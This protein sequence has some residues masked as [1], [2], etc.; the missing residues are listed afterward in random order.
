MRQRPIGI[1]LLSTLALLAGIGAAFQA[2]TSLDP[3]SVGPVG[4]VQAGGGF[5]PAAIGYMIAAGI[6]VQ[7]SYGPWD[8]KRWAWFLAPALAIVHVAFNI[9]GALVGGPTWALAGVGSVIPLVILAYLVTAGVR[10]A[11]RI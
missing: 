11:F 7:L 5:G 1:T 6:Y 3:G 8:M 4:N 2:F 9:G 10:R